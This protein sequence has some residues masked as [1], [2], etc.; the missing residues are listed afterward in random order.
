MMQKLLRH[1]FQ[2]NGDGARMR[3]GAILVA[4]VAL[5]CNAEEFRQ[6]ARCNRCDEGACID[7]MDCTDMAEW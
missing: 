4:A 6:H 7:E 2:L 1:C 3:S 5:C